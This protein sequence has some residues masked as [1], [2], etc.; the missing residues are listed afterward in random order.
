MSGE[1]EA[2]EALLYTFTE[3]CMTPLLAKLANVL[4]GIP[5]YH[6]IHWRALGK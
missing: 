2:R 6:K 4:T 3:E 5:D 1:M